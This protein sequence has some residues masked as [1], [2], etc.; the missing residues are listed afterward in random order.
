MIAAEVAHLV[1]MVTLTLCRSIIAMVTRCRWLWAPMQLAVVCA[2]Q[3]MDRS[4][5]NLPEV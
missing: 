1:T 5:C 4:S 3:P 2:V